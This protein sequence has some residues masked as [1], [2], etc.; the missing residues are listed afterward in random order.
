M[1]IHGKWT[2]YLDRTPLPLR[3][4][5]WAFVHDDYDGA[6]DGNDNR[7]GR[8]ASPEACIEA[9]LEMEDAS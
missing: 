6:P 3:Q 5:D 9:I 7:C 1:I 2:I 4:F 8:A